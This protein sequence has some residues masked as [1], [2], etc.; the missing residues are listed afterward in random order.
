MSWLDNAFYLNVCVYIMNV[1]TL[2]DV[3]Y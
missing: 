1:V 2:I 3:R